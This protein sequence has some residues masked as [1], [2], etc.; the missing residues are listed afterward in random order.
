MSKEILELL[1]V[2]VVVVTVGCG[3]CSKSVFGVSV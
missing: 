3:D 1:V 2:V